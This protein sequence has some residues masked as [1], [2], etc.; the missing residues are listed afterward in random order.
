M[1]WAV[2]ALLER[3]PAHDAAHVGAHRRTHIEFSAPIPARGKLLQA[4]WLGGRAESAPPKCRQAATAMIRSHECRSTCS[5]AID[6]SRGCAGDPISS[7]KARW[8]AGLG[9]AANSARSG[10][11]WRSRR[12]PFDGDGPCA[13]L[14]GLSAAP[15]PRRGG[16][17]SVFCHIRIHHGLCLGRRVRSASCAAFVL[18]AARRAHRATLL[19]RK[20]LGPCGVSIGRYRSRDARPFVGR[21][22]CVV[23]VRALCPTERPSS[24]RCSRSAGR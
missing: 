13:A 14:A 6:C 20:R 9:L 3:I 7:H 22:R 18:R 1:A 21:D 12:A 5:C 24:G 8:R 4:G 17:R 10:R 23:S 15:D 16:R 19:G 2:P 11:A